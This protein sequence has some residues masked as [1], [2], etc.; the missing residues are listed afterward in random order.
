MQ[1]LF[2]CLKLALQ[3]I[4]RPPGHQ[5]IGLPARPN[6]RF[7]RAPAGISTISKILDIL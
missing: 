5:L 1:S 7:P 4:T 6:R 2:F 3:L